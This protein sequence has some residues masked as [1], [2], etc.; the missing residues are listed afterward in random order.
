LILSSVS[1]KIKE[2]NLSVKPRFLGPEVECQGYRREH[3]ESQE[4]VKEI[5]LVV[6]G[7]P[8]VHSETEDYLDYH[9]NEQQHGEKLVLV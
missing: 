7:P 5:D 8:S 3:Q 6:G 4:D 9:E 1:I 2:K